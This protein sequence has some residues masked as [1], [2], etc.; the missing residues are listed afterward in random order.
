MNGFYGST[1]GFTLIEVLVAMTL[2]SVM[3]VLLFGSLKISAESW[4]RGENKITQVNKAA[5]VYNFFQRY[6]QNVMPLWSDTNKAD[7]VFSFQGQKNA[8]KFVSVR[9]A[10][11]IGPREQVYTV[12]LER[13]G[14]EQALKVTI[15]PFFPSAEG[16]EWRSDEE[17]L[18]HR[19]NSLSFEY[20]GLEDGGD[21]PHWQD[22]WS[23]RAQLP[24]LI[25]IRIDADGQNFW[26]DLIVDVKTSFAPLGVSVTGQEQDDSG[27]SSDNTGDS[28]DPEGVE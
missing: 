8:L 20:F 25:K 2:F 15:M 27:L 11:F 16:E 1:R 23:G 4:E 14:R 19:V 5:A 17:I 28:R 7:R 21:N 3:L 24:K 22:D 9:P 12:S 6:L 10:S 13:V 18:L 26:P